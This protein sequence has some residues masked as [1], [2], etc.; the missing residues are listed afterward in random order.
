[1]VE[2]QA[3][4]RIPFY[5]CKKLIMQI[6]ICEDFIIIMMKFERKTIKKIEVDKGDVEKWKYE[7]VEEKMKI[8]INI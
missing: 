2:G 8:Y 7:R 5:F 6:I 3:Q 1:M 4:D